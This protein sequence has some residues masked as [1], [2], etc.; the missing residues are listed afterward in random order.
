MISRAVG[1]YLKISPRK[2][3]EVIALIKGKGVTDALCILKNTNKRAAI[4]LSK[5]L[6]SAI[7][8]TKYI[9]NIREEDLYICG[10]HADGGPALKRYKAQAMG[11][12]AMIK[13]RTSHIT[14]MLDA[15]EDKALAKGIKTA[16]RLKKAKTIVEKP[17]SAETGF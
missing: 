12:A 7:A 16:A 10:L 5:L 11:R 4:F 2:V 15:R 13:R 17:K 1:R 14:I 6:N 8:N 3:R 9:P